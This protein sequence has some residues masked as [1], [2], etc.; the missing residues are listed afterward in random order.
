M[1]QLHKYYDIIDFNDKIDTIKVQFKNSNSPFDIIIPIDALDNTYLTGED[2]HK[3]I[4]TFLP[5][6]RPAPGKKIAAKNKEEI[7]KLVNKKEKDK[8]DVFNESMRLRNKRNILLLNSDWTQIAD[9]NQN[10]DEEDK[11]EWKNYRQKLRDITNQPGWPLDIDWPKRLH[12]LEVTI[13]E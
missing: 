13:Y 1:E 5:V 9:A 10:L 3:Y 2:L 8:L 6:D 12:R 4:M 11:V 7:H